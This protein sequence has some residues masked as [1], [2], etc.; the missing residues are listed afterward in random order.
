MF[1]K[2]RILFRF[3]KTEKWP[4]FIHNTVFD[5]SFS[6]RFDLTHFSSQL[7]SAQLGFLFH[8]K[9]CTFSIWFWSAIKKLSEFRYA[10]GKN[11][12]CEANVAVMFVD[13]RMK[14]FDSKSKCLVSGAFCFNYIKNVTAIHIVWTKC[15]TWNVL[16]LFFSS[17]WFL[18]L[19]GFVLVQSSF[20]FC[21]WAEFLVFLGT[22]L[23]FVKTVNPSAAHLCSWQS[24]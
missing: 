2:F 10:T 23:P 7:S 13:G 4:T 24:S 22:L 11:I 16:S 5:C 15:V 18:V 17:A 8:E 9:R 21:F 1:H 14:P 20:F 6:L 19:F 3:E 12:P